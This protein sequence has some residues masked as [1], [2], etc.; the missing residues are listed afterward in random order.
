MVLI[1][2]NKESK[3]LSYFTYIEVVYEYFSIHEP[4]DS[5]MHSHYSYILH[6]IIWADFIVGSWYSIV[7]WA[8]FIVGSWQYSWYGQIL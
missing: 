7:V 3:N 5:P 8:D 2:K 1:F 6:I 4:L